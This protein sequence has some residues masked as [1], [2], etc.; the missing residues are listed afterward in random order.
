[1]RIGRV[2]G[3]FAFCAMLILPAATKAACVLGNS[4]GSREFSMPRNSVCLIKR[5]EVFN[6]L[7]SMRVSV[8]P[9]LG[10]FG[11]SSVYEFAYRSGNVAGDDYFEY[12]SVQAA[13]N[14]P[15]KEY[16]VRNVVHITP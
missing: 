11:Q 8:K 6:K 1:M 2:A 10:Q 14:G 5:T 9:K 13:R 3:V 15:A 7:I 16:R 4:L 12:I